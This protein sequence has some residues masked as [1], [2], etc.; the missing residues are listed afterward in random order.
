MAWHKLI[1]SCYICS[2]WAYCLVFIRL[3][4]IH[5]RFCQRAFSVSRKH[6]TFPSSTCI[7][8]LRV[9]L[10]AIFA[11]AA[12][13]LKYSQHWIAICTGGSKFLYLLAAAAM[14]YN[15]SNNQQ[16]QHSRS[17]PPRQNTLTWSYHNAKIFWELSLL[18]LFCDI[19][20]SKWCQNFRCN[21]IVWK[22]LSEEIM[23]NTFLKDTRV[24]K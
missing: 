4:S 17:I 15:Y 6:F 10:Y 11:A 20:V 12:V 13:C 14:I 24:S 22:D 5:L 18:N 2:Q 3:A 16:Q 21:L 8:L 9:I 1:G 7:D 19:R 23:I